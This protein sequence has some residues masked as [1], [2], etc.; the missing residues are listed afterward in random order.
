MGNIDRAIRIVF[1]VLVAVLYLSGA[2]NGSV[3]AVLGVA[4]I[5]MVATSAVSFCP[6][7]VPLGISTRKKEIEGKTT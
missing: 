4:A 6:L 7:Y 1:A 3:A 5:I 2:I